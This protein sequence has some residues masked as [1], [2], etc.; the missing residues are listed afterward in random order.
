MSNR[1]TAP[2]PA[3]LLLRLGLAIIFLSHGGLKI[4]F[5]STHWS[6]EPLPPAMQAAVAWGEVAVGFACL[7]GLLTRLACLGIIV[8]MV[9]AMWVETG[10]RISS[11]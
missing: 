10:P 11:R 3:S 9:G 4:A 5:G 6:S 1:F 2:A 8:I 7:L